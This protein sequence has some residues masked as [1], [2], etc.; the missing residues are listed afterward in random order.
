MSG[1]SSEEECVNHPN[2]GRGKFI[3]Y[4]DRP[5]WVDVIQVPQ[6]D[7][8]NPI[9]SIAYSEKCKWGSRPVS[10]LLLTLLLHF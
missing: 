10:F 2:S 4:R 3:L 9:V 8:P 5:E 1:S 6:N 7:G